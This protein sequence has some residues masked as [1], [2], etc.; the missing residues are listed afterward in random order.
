MKK[1]PDIQVP[2][3]TLVD[4]KDIVRERPP[5]PPPPPPIEIS[6]SLVDEPSL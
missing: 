3:F 2:L 4:V 1:E 5:S 6:C